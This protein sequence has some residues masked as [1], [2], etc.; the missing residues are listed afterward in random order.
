MVKRY[1]LDS[2]V[3]VSAKTGEGVKEMFDALPTKIAEKRGYENAASA[4]REDYKIRVTSTAR[5][6]N[7]MHDVL[8]C[9]IF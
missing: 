6:N 2:Y 3:E 5:N 9:N 7:I 4:I 1:D 8:C